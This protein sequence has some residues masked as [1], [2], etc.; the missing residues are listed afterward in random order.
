MLYGVV[1]ESVGD[2]TVTAVDAALSD[3]SFLWDRR[4]AL[5]CPSCGG[6]HIWLV[7]LLGIRVCRE[8]WRTL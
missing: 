8:C 6:V 1:D 5:V 3:W 2:A 4:P 7:G